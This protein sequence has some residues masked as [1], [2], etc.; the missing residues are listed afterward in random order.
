MK[1]KKKVKQTR[2]LI[3][4]CALE[5]KK[6]MI[7]LAVMPILNASRTLS[8]DNDATIMFGN[9]YISSA[10]MSMMLIFRGESIFFVVVSNRIQILLIET[11]RER[12]RERK[13]YYIP[14]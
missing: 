14:V 10:N 3:C 7:C 13:L 1:M 11:D 4:E 2:E 12:E 6:F 5:R 8:L 9:L